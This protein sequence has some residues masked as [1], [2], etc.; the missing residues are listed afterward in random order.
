MSDA[1]AERGKELEEAFFRRLNEKTVAD[2]KAR[3]ELAQNRDGIGKLTGITNTGLLD[4]LAGLNLSPATVAAFG[5][6]PLV[7]VAWADGTVD[8][9]EQR[10]VLDAATQVGVTGPG[11]DVL[12]QWLAAKPS[13]EVFA[14]WQQ[15]A[16]AVVARLSDADKQLMKHEMLGRARTVAEASGGIL[17]LGN[18]VSSAEAAVLKK[19]EDSF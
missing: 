9:K 1:I 13:A 18:K 19:I 10:A 14:A 17:G 16:S 15:Y 5:L 12:T 3:A 11:L 6:L 4:T 8:A 2:L 7:E